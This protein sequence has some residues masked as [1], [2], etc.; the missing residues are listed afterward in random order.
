MS[1]NLEEWDIRYS[2]VTDAMYLKKWL[3]IPEI[4]HW[5]PLA[6]GAEIEGAV[7]SWMGMSRYG[8]S[9]TVTIENVPCAMGV[10]FLM[11]YKKVAHHCMF[12]LV[13]DPNYQRKG[14]GESLIK[15]LKHLAKTYF[16]IELIHIEIVEGNPILSLLLKMGFH[17]F[18]RQERFFKED[19]SYFGRI[20]LESAL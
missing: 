13:V 6:T 14:I 18:G 12:K 11:P 10:L 20:L 7:Q 2:Y 19:D 17:E 16:K 9:L 3:A 15:N 5:F 1:R 8:A 4:L